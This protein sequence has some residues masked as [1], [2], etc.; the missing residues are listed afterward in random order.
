MRYWTVEEA[1]AYVPRVRALLE[2][3]L[4]PAATAHRARSNGHASVP[5]HDIDPQAALAELEAGSIIV[6][7]PSV[8][9]IDVPALDSKGETYLLCWRFDDG[10]ELG[11]WHLPDEGFVGRKPLPKDPA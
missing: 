4:Q 5:Q 7:D 3:L 6:R 11:W 9:L 2:A 1:R 10:D 8:G